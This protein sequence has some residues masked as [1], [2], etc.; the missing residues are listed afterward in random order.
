M[1]QASAKLNS[2][3]YVVVFEAVGYL[4]FKSL[5]LLNGEVIFFLMS[6]FFFFN[7]RNKV[8]LK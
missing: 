7:E 2:W 3:C 6:L 1:R 5:L 8:S 4:I